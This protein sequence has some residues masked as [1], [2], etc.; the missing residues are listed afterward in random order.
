[1]ENCWL[2]QNQ[3]VQLFPKG[4]MVRSLH[5]WLWKGQTGEV[6]GYEFVGPHAFVSVQFDDSNIYNNFPRN[7]LEIVK[8]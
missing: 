3:L 1:M 6:V 4:S 5:T 8:T 7:E 2:V